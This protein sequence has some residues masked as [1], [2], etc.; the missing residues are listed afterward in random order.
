MRAPAWARKHPL[1]QTKTDRHERALRRLN[2]KYLEWGPGDLR[3]DL[4]YNEAR[5]RLRGRGRDF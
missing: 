1:L 4:R 5:R 2:M 3:A